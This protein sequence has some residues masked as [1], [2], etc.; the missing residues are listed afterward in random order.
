MLFG[1]NAKINK[2]E[3]SCREL[4]YYKIGDQYIDFHFLY[5]NTA[6]CF[7]RFLS[8]TTILNPADIISVSTSHAMI[9]QYC[10]HMKLDDSYKPKAEYAVLAYDT[11]TQLLKKDVCMLHSVAVCYHGK[12]ILFTGPSG[13]GKTTMYAQWKRRYG[14]EAGIISGDLP[15]LVV[16]QNGKIMVMPSPWN[17][18][19]HLHSGRC[20]ELGGIIILEQSQHNRVERLSPEQSILP[21]YD[22]ICFD[23]EEKDNIR[24][25]FEIEE[26][27]LNTVPVWKLYSKGNLQAAEVCYEGIKEELYDG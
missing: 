20:E 6:S 24:T 1:G 9:E 19:E 10:R 16:K 21:I 26:K 11:A 2:K 5:P 8:Y 22:Q 14:N 17:G 27:L 18:K 15:A 13:I 23:R 7:Q 25:C 3:K 12:A 4:I